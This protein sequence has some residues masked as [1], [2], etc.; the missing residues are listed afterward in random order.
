MLESFEN[1]G[2]YFSV[3]LSERQ[4]IYPQIERNAQC[5]ERQTKQVLIRS[6]NTLT[7]G[8]RLLLTERRNLDYPK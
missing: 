8:D 4:N 3:K 6:N 2:F 1:F 5:Q 7:A